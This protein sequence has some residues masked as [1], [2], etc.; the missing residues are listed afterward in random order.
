MSHF[1]EKISPKNDQVA[2]FLE[3]LVKGSWIFFWNRPRVISVIKYRDTAP[4][5]FYY[6]IIINFK[7]TSQNLISWPGQPNKI[8]MTSRIFSLM[9][10]FYNQFRGCHANKAIMPFTCV[11]SKNF[12]GSTSPQI[13]SLLSKYHISERCF[14]SLV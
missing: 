3:H 8:L 7:T 1:G 10:T 12:F 14:R 2:V 9:F 11:C 6:L 13:E 5:F 4:M